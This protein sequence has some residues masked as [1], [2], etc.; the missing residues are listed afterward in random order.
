MTPSR[1]DRGAFASWWFTVDRQLVAAIVALVLTGVVVSLAAGPTVAG[2]KGLAT[3]YFVERHALFALAGLAIVLALSF[4][5][6]ALVRR[7]SLVLFIG[8]LLLM[9]AAVLF[10]EEINGARRWVRI[11]GQSLQPSELTK[12][13]FVILTAWLL[14]ERLRRP[15][16]PAMAIAVSAWALLAG[17]LVLQPDIGQT[18]LVTLVWGGMLFVAGVSLRWLLALGTASVAGLAAAYFTMPYVKRRFDAFFFPD[19]AETY[20]LDRAR[21]SFVEGGWFGQGPGEGRVKSLLPDA[22]TDFVLAVIAEEYG[23]VACLVL[24]GLFVFVAVRALAHVWSEEDAFVRNAC[25][26][27]VMLFSFQT[28]INMAVNVGL[29]P[30]KGMTLPFLSYG[31]SSLVGNAVAMGLLVAVTRRR[32]GAARL[33]KTMFV[34]SEE[35][36]LPAR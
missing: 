4:A 35:P 26:G 5:G 24:I 16:V 7:F 22:H 6:R 13:A 23:I 10:G 36:G 27:L 19:S 8:G 9:V 30:A 32:P 1:A 34:S 18:V 2:K 29:A 33:K 11:L 21:Q 31:G 20:Q 25:A 28:L 12:P 3:Y 14:A 17:L 15:D